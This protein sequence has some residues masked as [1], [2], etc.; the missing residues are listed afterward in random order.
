MS[1]YF[2][3]FRQDHTAGIAVEQ[4]DSDFILQLVQLLLKRGGGNKQLFGG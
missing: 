2:S 1:K 4:P 3:G